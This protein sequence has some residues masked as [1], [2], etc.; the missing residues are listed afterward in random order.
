MHLQ[1]LETVFVFRVQRISTDFFLFLNRF[2]VERIIFISN[3]FFM[4]A[5]QRII[6]KIYT[7]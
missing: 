5:E 7:C 6:Q 4:L 2:K 3:S 1:V